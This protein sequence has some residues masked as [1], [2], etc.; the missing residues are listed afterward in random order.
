MSTQR[1]LDSLIARAEANLVSET[2][3][4]NPATKAIAAAIAGV[5]YGQYG[6]QDLLFRQLHPETCSEEWLYLHANR[7]KVP[8][9]LPTFATG[10]VQFTE[11]GTAVVIKKGTRLKQA[12]HE[13]EITKEQYSNVPVGVI[14]LE[15]GVE[16]NLPE[17]AVLT[18]SEGLSGIDPNRVLSLGIGAGANIEELEHWR[19]RVIVAFEKNELIGKAVDY[20]VWAA[21]A[22]SDVDFAWAL[23]NTPQRGMVEVY[24]GT[25]ENNPTLSAEVVK[26]VQNTFEQNRLAGCHP[27]AHL[28]EQAPIKI[29][30]QGIE[31]Q[32]VRDDVVTALE[33]LVK[34]KMGKIDP[35]TQKPESITNT[36]IVL[37]ISTVTNNFIVRSPV[38][39]V[40]I[41]NNQIH[42]LGGVTWT[43]PT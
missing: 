31:D 36:E 23:D 18:L 5:S 10:R 29:E 11:L 26:L 28:P 27:V 33:N 14:A 32:V 25:R 17:G 3:Q 39:E 7:H 6:Y 41:E 21:S 15:S 43:P 20:E 40:T 35:T 30:I 2:G 4:N 24:I 12:N 19:M 38:G 13:Y 34:V 9:L 42:V 22:H 37:T 16:S 8:R 1:S